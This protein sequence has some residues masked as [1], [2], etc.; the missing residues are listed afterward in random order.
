MNGAQFTLTLLTVV[1]LACGSGSAGGGANGGAGHGNA[2]SAG[3]GSGNVS[4]GGADAVADGGALDEAPTLSAADLAALRTLSPD[5]LPSPGPDLS[6]RFA[7]D[8]SAAAFGQRLFFDARFSGRLLDGDNDGSADALGK[9]GDTGKVACAGCH[10]PSAGFVDNRS[11][12]GQISLAAGWGRRKA[13]SLLDIGQASLLTWD[14]RRDAL[15]NQPFAPIESPV[16]MNSSRLFAAEQIYAN[17][18]SEYEAIFGPM[19]P[20]DDAQRFPQ[21]TAAQTGCHPSTVDTE[22]TCTGVEDGIPG[23]AAEFDGLSAAD[24]DLVTGVVVNAGKALGAY[25]RLLSCGAGRF[26]QWMHGQTDALS[27]SEQRGAQIFVGR[28][29]CVTCHSGP[30]L[31]DHEFHNVGL[32]PGTVAVVFID[33]N[34][35]GASDGLAA[36]IADPLNVRGHFSDGDDGRLPTTVGAKLLGA[37]QT[38]MLRCGAKRPSFMH[39]G[40]LATLSAVV[41]FFARG[42]DSFGFPGKSEIAPL[43]L[44][45]Q[46]QADLVA[47]LGTLEGPGPATNLLTSP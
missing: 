44:T 47:F 17:H 32:Q 28:G 38:P 29:Q 21:L 4:N 40:Q 3:A 37:F 35:N 43:D 22:P 10:V 9:V 5:T 25:E 30:Y 24:Q 11:L 2:T 14:G 23:D 27:A 26:D 15:Y 31:S 36:A 18:R 16:E 39:T 20:L 8:P 41:S 42:G 33:S 19:P 6:N 12:G 1:S 34:D 45:A 7:D 46:A 13:P